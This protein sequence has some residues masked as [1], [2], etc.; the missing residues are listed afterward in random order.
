[1]FYTVID[2][3]IVLVLWS[4]LVVVLYWTVFYWEVLLMF[5][6]YVCKWRGQK[7]RKPS[8]Y[9]RPA[10]PRT[11]TLSN[12]III[13]FTH[14]RRCQQ[15][16]NIINFAKVDFMA[17]L[18]YWI[19]L[20]CTDVLNKVSTE[21]ITLVQN[22]LLNT[23]CCLQ[24]KCMTTTILATTS[25]HYVA[26]WKCMLKTIIYTP[27]PVRVIKLWWSTCPSTWLSVIHHP[28]HACKPPPSPASSC[29]PQH[30]Y[31]QHDKRQALSSEISKSPGHF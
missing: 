31:S 10:P 27:W 1:M 22:Y 23:N 21:C 18:L 16:L 15:K 9:N 30:N 13:K 7:I 29:A 26:T 5:C 6:P 4:L 2:G 3:L 28:S 24:N 14:F 19:T 11:M 12:T 25:F 17:G 8:Q 20:D